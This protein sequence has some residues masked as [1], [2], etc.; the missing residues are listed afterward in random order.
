MWIEL[1]WDGRLVVLL[2]ALEVRWEWVGPAGNGADSAGRRIRVWVDSVRDEGLEEAVSLL[3]G[4]R[5]RYEEGRELQLSLPGI[6][7][8]GTASPAKPAGWQ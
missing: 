4:L 3:A 8:L 5:W 7:T 1:E 2:A 6:S